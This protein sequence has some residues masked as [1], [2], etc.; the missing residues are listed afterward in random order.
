M[1]RE[2]EN[3]TSDIPS[4]TYFSAYASA[5]PPTRIAELRQIFIVGMSPGWLR[6]NTT[7]D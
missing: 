7:A 1:L 2:S 3:L 5:S 4:E 6:D